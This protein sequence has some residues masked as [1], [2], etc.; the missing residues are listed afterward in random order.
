[1]NG[2]EI[3]TYHHSAEQAARAYDKLA[4]EACGKFAYLNFPDD[5]DALPT[6]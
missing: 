3:T 4:F 6:A 1:M 5:Y 2:K